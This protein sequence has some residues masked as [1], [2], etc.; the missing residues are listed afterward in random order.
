VNINDGKARKLIATQ[1]CE[2]HKAT[3]VQQIGKMIVLV[4]A[5]KKPNP[6]LSNLLKP[7]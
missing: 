1:L 3:L 2:S 6:K 7:A 5:A 4:R